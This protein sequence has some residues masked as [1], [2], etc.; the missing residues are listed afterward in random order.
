[1]RII[2]RSIIVQKTRKN[3][4]LSPPRARASDERSKKIDIRSSSSSGILRVGVCK[5]MPALQLLRYYII[6]IRQEDYYY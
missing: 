5:L 3:R 1:M 2:I 6:I 4:N